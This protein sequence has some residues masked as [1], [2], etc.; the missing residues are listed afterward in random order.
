MNLLRK[1]INEM[2]KRWKFQVSSERVHAEER[3][4]LVNAAGR[5]I[6]SSVG[7]RCVSRFV[8]HSC[9]VSCVATCKVGERKVLQGELRDAAEGM[10]DVSVCRRVELVKERIS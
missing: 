6:Q 8:I 9:S 2:R 5:A 3:L 10:N 4:V 1:E 7:L